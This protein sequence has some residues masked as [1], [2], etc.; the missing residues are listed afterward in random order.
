M[1]VMHAYDYAIPDGRGVIG[2][3]WLKPALDDAKVA[4]R[5]QQECVNVLIDRFHDVLSAICET[6]PDHFKLVDSR[7]TLGPEDWANELHPTKQGFQKLVTR[8]WMP[9]LQNIGL[10]R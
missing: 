5:L 7:G 10:A 6:D 2:E 9:V 3:S 4:A 8:K 1:V